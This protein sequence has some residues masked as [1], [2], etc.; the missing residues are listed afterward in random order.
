[1]L[2]TKGMSDEA[3]D[4]RLSIQ[5][6]KTLRDLGELKRAL[7]Q[8]EEREKQRCRQNTQAD[9]ADQSEKSAPTINIE[10]VQA[11]KVWAFPLSFP[12]DS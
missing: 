6:D 3:D 9:V 2:Q 5:L 11:Q 10:E 12:H 7:E 4:E 1:M 8:E